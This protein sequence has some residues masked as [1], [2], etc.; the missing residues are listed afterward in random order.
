MEDEEAERQPERSS[1]MCGMRA[2]TRT[3]SVE[4]ANVA[5]ADA[6][7]QRGVVIPARHEST[8]RG[9]MSIWTR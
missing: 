2:R 6:T 5:T 3:A 7:M 4:I 1:P 9:K 8:T